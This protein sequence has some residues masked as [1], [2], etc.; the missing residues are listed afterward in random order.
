MLDAVLCAHP[1]EQHLTGAG[2]E[3]VREELA[4]CQ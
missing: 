1:I 2:A 3:S 4:V